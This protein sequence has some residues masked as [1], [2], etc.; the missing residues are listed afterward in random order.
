M[1]IMIILGLKLLLSYQAHGDLQ[2]CLRAHPYPLPTT[3]VMGRYGWWQGARTVFGTVDGDAHMKKP[4][5]IPAAF[6][7]SFPGWAGSENLLS[8]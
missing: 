3:Q 1:K 6:P 2:K 5:G 4:P 7:G 8:Q